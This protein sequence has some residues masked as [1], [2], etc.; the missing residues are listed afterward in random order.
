MPEYAGGFNSAAMTFMLCMGVLMLVV[1]RRYAVLPLFAAAS[2]MTMAQ[3]IE[4]AGLN[5]TIIRIL[6]L[7]GWVRIAIRG[8]FR[9]IRINS[10]DKA[11][12]WW[13]ASS[14]VI[15]TL[16]WQTGQS[17]VY[18]CGQAYDA[19]GLY[20]FFRALI[21]DVEDI[22]SVFR[23]FALLLV[24]LAGLMMLEKATGQNLFAVFGGVPR[25]TLVREG[26][27]R[28]QGPFPHSILAGTFAAALLPQFVALWWQGGSGRLLSLLGVGSVV[29]ITAASGSS[30]PVMTF[31]CGMVGLLFWWWR[32]EM[33]KVRWALIGALVVVQ[34]VMKAPFWFIIAHLAVRQGSDAFYRAF[35]I[36]R[37]IAHFSE[38]WLIGSRYQVPWATKLTDITNM[39]V[40]IALDGG[41]ITLILFFTVLRRAFAG[42]GRSIRA[43]VNERTIQ[44][45]CIWALGATLFAHVMTFL[46]VWYWDQNIVNWYLL[47]AMIGSISSI[48]ALVSSDAPVKTN[49]SVRVQAELQPLGHLELLLPAGSEAERLPRPW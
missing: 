40:R 18:R 34:F 22:K 39:Y 26:V 23:M 36:D 45:R 2:Y 32:F 48:P 14:I 41:L 11:M 10:L 35:L 28:C 30:G 37:T 13:T 7:V 9:A 31:L 24:P 20:I 47:L 16:L 5:F 15:Y 43:K 17:F 4:I 46:A 49:Q 27:L 29:I 6:T 42:V 21:R 8:E 1:P 12:F 44:Q 33:R 19:I 25:T 38:W 3:R